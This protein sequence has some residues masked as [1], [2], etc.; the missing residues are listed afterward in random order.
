MVEWQ[1]NIIFDPIASR[2]ADPEHRGLPQV[3]LG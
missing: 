2:E 1:F 3:P